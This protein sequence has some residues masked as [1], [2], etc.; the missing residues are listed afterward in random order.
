MQPAARGGNSLDRSQMSRL[1]THSH[2]P[3]LLSVLFFPPGPL[4]LLTAGLRGPPGGCLGPQ[5]QG[6]GG[7]S[8]LRLV[9]D[10]SSLHPQKKPFPTDDAQP[11]TWMRQSAPSSGT[12]RGGVSLL[13]LN[14]P[15]FGRNFGVW[16][17]SEFSPLRE[18]RGFAQGSG[19]AEATRQCAAKARLAEELTFHSNIWQVINSDYRPV[20][21]GLAKPLSYAR[22]SHPAR[23]KK[24]SRKAEDSGG[25]GEK[26][27][28][29]GGPHTGADGGQGPRLPAAPGFAAVHTK[30]LRPGPIPRELRCTGGER[31]GGWRGGG[32]GG[33]QMHVAGA[34]KQPPSPRSPPA[35][36]CP[37]P[38]HAAKLWG[39]TAPWWQ[40]DRSGTA[41]KPPRRRC[42]E[43]WQSHGAAG[44]V[45]PPRRAQPACDSFLCST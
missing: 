12:G 40:G 37:Q 33:H 9:V 28:P 6:P 27:H 23:R 32:R 29:P 2:F 7:V 25:G 21:L 8:A 42:T 14:P 16:G 15:F 13:S 17:H 31:G 24:G 36:A 44:T 43:P 38:P 22:L 30:I 20:E 39:H 5:P 4:L 41:P 1:R 19:S 3:L 11:N 34:G 26:H 10:F 45:P 18:T 35:P